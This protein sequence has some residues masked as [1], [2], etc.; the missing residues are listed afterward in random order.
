M[1]QAGKKL[2]SDTSLNIGAKLR[3]MLLE[4]YNVSQIDAIMN[5]AKREKDFTLIQGPPGTGKTK[6]ICGILSCILRNNT[7]HTGD[8]KMDKKRVLIC[9]PSNA[10]VDEIMI[11]LK[12]TGLI[13][14][15]G[16][17][18]SPTMVRLG[19]QNRVH[20]E[21]AELY[22][23]TQI[24]KELNKK[25]DTITQETSESMIYFDNLTMYRN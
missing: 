25:K 10:S 18:Y 11:R 17:R 3:E 16:K 1:Y 13:D 2:L 8:S 12:K 5:A 4:Q 14:N 21:I 20:H 7:K 19:V 6:T 22:L 15:D 9:A 23:A 24:T